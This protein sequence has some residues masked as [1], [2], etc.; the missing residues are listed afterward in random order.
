MKFFESK[1]Y[2]GK[3][4]EPPTGVS[5]V[6]A[7]NLLREV[8]F[9]VDGRSTLPWSGR[10]LNEYTQSIPRLPDHHVDCDKVEKDWELV[11]DLV[12]YSNYVGTDFTSDNIDTHLDKIYFNSEFE[13]FIRLTKKSPDEY[14]K[15]GTRSIRLPFF[16]EPKNIIK[17]LKEQG[18]IVE[19]EVEYKPILNV[20]VMKPDGFALSSTNLPDKD[21]D[22]EHMYPTGFQD[23]SDKMVK[24]VNN[25]D[26]GLLILHGPPGTGKTS[27]IRWLSGQTKRSFVFIP[28]DM[29][30][31]LSKP[32]FLEFLMQNRGLTFIVEDAETILRPRDEFENSVVSTILGLTDGLLG[33]V[34]SCQFICTFNSNLEDVDSALRRPGRLLIEHE[35]GLLNK[36]EANKYLDKY[37]IDYTIEDDYISLAELTNTEAPMTSNLKTVKRGIGFLNN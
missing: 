24:I 23:V 15:C 20:L 9:L 26:T 37:E 22:I 32:T 27:Y 25:D 13:C 1:Y 14:I 11:E 28:T 6:G 12:C 36:D 3:H 35:F 17:S 30:S 5:S 31:S 7:I 34:L 33:D 21:I 19:T 18:Y 8:T 2:T 29:V 4:P 16:V 10:V